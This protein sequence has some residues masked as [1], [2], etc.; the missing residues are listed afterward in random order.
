M[1]FE[2]IKSFLII[3]HNFTNSLLFFFKELLKVVCTKLLNSYK[4]I[5]R[6]KS[7]VTAGLN[8][9][10]S[11]SLVLS[12]YFSRNLWALMTTFLNF[13][14]NIIKTNAHFN[15]FVCSVWIFRDSFLV[16]SSESFQLNLIVQCPRMKTFSL[17]YVSEMYLT[18]LTSKYLG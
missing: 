2:F 10:F 13:K 11:F 6:S 14:R 17:T 4:W 8:R 3:S 12:L 15:V 1:N 16:C 18:Y 9:I 7:S 5:V